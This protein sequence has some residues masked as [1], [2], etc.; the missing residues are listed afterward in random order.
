MVTSL[1]PPH[2]RRILEAHIRKVSL[3]D[4]HFVTT[5]LDE[6]QN[7]ELKELIRLRMQGLPLQYLVG[8][9]AFFG[10]EFYVNTSVLVPRPETEGLVEITITEVRKR[11]TATEADAVTGL[12]LGTGSGCIAATLALELPS[13]QIVATDCCSDALEVA[14]ENLRRLRAP[15]VSLKEVRNPPHLSDYDYLPDLDFIVSNPP[16]LLKKV[17]DIAT[18]VRMHEPELA[19]YAPAEAPLGYYDFLAR[20]SDSK[21]K[22]DG[23]LL[24]ETA[25]ERADAVKDIFESKMRCNVEI[26]PDLTGRPRYV[27]AYQ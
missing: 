19:L 3:S 15:N 16:Y 24:V 13:V 23:L 9:Q 18:D 5:P 20:L 4:L 2:E 8:T 17:D 25:H 22:K 6:Y 26:R 11:L 12:D 27:I 14:A 21:L 10:R 1:I 7:R